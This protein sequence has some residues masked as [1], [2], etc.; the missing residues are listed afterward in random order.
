MSVPY[1]LTEEENER[2]QQAASDLLDDMGRYVH[3]R[4]NDLDDE[5]WDRLNANIELR[6]RQAVVQIRQLKERHGA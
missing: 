5:T 2:V 4:P 3:G 6:M 1:Q